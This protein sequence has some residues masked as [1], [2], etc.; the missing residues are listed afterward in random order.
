MFL[1]SICSYGRAGIGLF[2]P[3]VAYF[4]FENEKATYPLLRRTTRNVGNLRVPLKYILV[5]VVAIFPG[6]NSWTAH[7]TAWINQ[8]NVVA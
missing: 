8:R 7:N 2:Q 3:L 5:I 6:I 1:L 4:D